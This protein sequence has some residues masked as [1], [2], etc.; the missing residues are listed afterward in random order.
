MES[1]FAFLILLA[2]Q[3][4]SAH[5][6][7]TPIPV[8]P[9][10]VEGTRLVDSAK[11]SF[12]LR[13]VNLPGIDTEQ[14][15]MPFTFRVIQQR[16]N[17]NTVRLPVSPA[18]W[19]RDGPPYFDRIANVV[20]AANNEGLVA[21]LAAYEDGSGL[22]GPELPAFWTACAA[23]F[24]NT[25]GVIFALY[26]EPST[27]NIPASDRLAQWQIWRN[28]GALTGGRSAVGMQSLVD[29]IRATGAAQVIAA[30]SF[31]DPLGFQGFAANAFLRDANVI[32]EVH[33]FFDQ[34]LTDDARDAAFGF[35]TGSF[36]VFAGAWG[37]PLGQNS[38]ACRAVP[39]DIQQATDLLLRTMA[40]F[41]RRNVSWA[42][43][44][45]APGSLVQNL[46]DYAPTV[47]NGAVSCEPTADPR[48][49]IGQWVLLTMTG[50][51]NGF[52]SLD[53]ALVAGVAGF[54]SQPIAPGEIVSIFGQLVGPETPV[55][56]QL[57]DAGRVTNAIADLQVFFNG[58]AAPVLL[59][60]YFQ[61]NV[62]VPLELAGQKTVEM[63]L[64]YRGVPSNKITMP[65]VD[66]APLL[67]T[68]LGATLAAALNQDGRL[69]DEL[70][71]AAAGSVVS[72]FAT[73]CGQSTP[74]LSTGQPA[75]GAYPLVLPAFFRVAGQAA[76]VLYTGTAPGYLGVSQ[77]N[78]R[79]PETLPAGRVSVMLTVGGA[80]SRPGITVWVK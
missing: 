76:E 20:R 69:N 79:L 23:A 48:T 24:K 72:F 66:S 59:A 15:V 7:P 77:I 65:M 61:D 74:A 71:P 17:M 1:R 33:P 63:Q 12:L 55:G 64:V 52:G 9:L 47:M 40:Y 54:A 78:V 16:W 25:G 28:G 60:G 35:L 80:E 14:A 70:S 30:P 4:V 43:S 38:A 13:G 75:A 50:D 26:N 41:D 58:M 45:F 21:V 37:V 44:D 32:Y 29:A 53:P 3:C 22:P 6:P 67:L 46:S 18:M 31:Q 57:D 62:Q 49:G 19:K 36:P 42:V 51:P 34:Q 8:P 2:A 39:S 56:P 27:R 68:N 10:H 73:G 5:A 11:T